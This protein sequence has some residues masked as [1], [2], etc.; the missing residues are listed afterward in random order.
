MDHNSFV[1]DKSLLNE[2]KSGGVKIKFVF[3]FFTENISSNFSPTIF[4]ILFSYFDVIL[5]NKGIC[6]VTNI[7]VS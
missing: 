5:C 2:R 7:N 4:L 6:S 3:M 1:L